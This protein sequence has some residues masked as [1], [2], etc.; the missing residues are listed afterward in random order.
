MSTTI[1]VAII[2]ALATIAGGATA[3]TIGLITQGRQL[4]EQRKVQRRQ[5]RRDAYVEFLSTH[6]DVFNVLM[7]IWMQPPTSNKST[8]I[9]NP[10]YEPIDYLRNNNIAANVVY[11]E[12]PQS[13]RSAAQAIIYFHNEQTAMIK[14]VALD[15]IGRTESLIDLSETSLDEV[16]EKRDVLADEFTNAATAALNN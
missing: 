13:V 14:K 4:G 8:R 9:L 16:Y 10:L 7:D 15:N 11:L 1:A 5:V 6:E 2:T 12:G 3:G